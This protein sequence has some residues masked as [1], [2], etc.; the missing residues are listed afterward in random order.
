MLYIDH[1]NPKVRNIMAAQAIMRASLKVLFN[2]RYTAT[3]KSDRLNASKGF[4]IV[5]DAMV[6][7]SEEIRTDPACWVEGYH[8]P[9]VVNSRVIT[10]AA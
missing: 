1:S 8:F 4:L 6:S 10:C 2:E 5:D 9:D 3:K 7:L